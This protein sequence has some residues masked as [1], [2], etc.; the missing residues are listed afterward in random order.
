MPVDRLAVA[1]L[2]AAYQHN[3]V[4]ILGGEP[5]LKPD[6]LF[7]L[8]RV[9]RAGGCPHRRR[10][11]GRTYEALLR[12]AR[13]QP[14][15]GRIL[16]QIDMLSDGPYVE[17]LADSADPWTGSGNQRVIDLTA[18]RRAGRVVVLEARP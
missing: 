8:V 2:N 12:R 7:A 11:C 17:A 9:L 14:A 4:S 10:Y 16:D 5:F 3:G 18:T 13:T 6:G 1:L 15:I